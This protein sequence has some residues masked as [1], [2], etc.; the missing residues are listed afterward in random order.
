MEAFNERGYYT[1]HFDPDIKITSKN[2]KR[3]EQIQERRDLSVYLGQAFTEPTAN[4]KW[5]LRKLARLNGLKKDEI[6]RLF[7]PTVDERIA[8]KENVLL[9]E[10]KMVPVQAE[11]NHLEH[12]EVHSM[13]NLTNATKAHIA[14]HERALSIKK[15]R[16]ELFPQD[17]PQVDE[18]G[19]PIQPGQGGGQNPFNPTQPGQS[20]AQALLQ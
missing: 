16:P 7:P 20:P 12:L 1:E 15:V 11:D 6:E 14:T 2:V 9:N 3:I 17:Q 19:Q 18:N 4:K 8:E 10:D 13:A 5:G